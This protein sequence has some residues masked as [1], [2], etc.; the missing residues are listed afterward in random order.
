[1]AA[2]LVIVTIFVIAGFAPLVGIDSRR[3]ERKWW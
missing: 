1:M 3:D 2:A